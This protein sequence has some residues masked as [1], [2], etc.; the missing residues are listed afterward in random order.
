MKAIFKICMTKICSYCTLPHKDNTVYVV[1]K[2]QISQHSFPWIALWSQGCCAPVQ[3]AD[4]PKAL[5]GLQTQLSFN[6][7]LLL[8]HQNIFQIPYFIPL[9][10]EDKKKGEKCS[11][12]KSL[13]LLMEMSLVL[14]AC[15][16]C[17]SITLS[18]DDTEFRK[19]RVFP[20]PSPPWKHN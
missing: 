18:I 17:S 13:T 16:G 6:L 8:L 11:V 4:I 7:N 3:T 1:Q 20:P 19:A 12:E 14:L 15:R 5:H 2:V 10:L 9:H